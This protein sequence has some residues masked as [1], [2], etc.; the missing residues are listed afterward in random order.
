MPG[1]GEEKTP[2]EIFLEFDADDSGE[3]DKSELV[4]ALGNAG[5]TVTTTQV[6]KLMSIIDTDNDGKI[7][8]A[9]FRAFVGTSKMLSK[10]DVVSKMEASFATAIRGASNPIDVASISISQANHANRAAQRTRAGSNVDGVDF[11]QNNIEN[12]LVVEVVRQLE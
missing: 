4:L 2:D 8:K 3:I 7:S 9:E 10:E 6:D 11:V 5:V 12:P 1:V